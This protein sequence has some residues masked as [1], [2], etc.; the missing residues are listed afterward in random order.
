MALHQELTARR[1]ERSALPVID[2]SGLASDDLAARRAVARELRAACLDKGFFYIANHG[3][4]TPLVDTLLE[5]AARFFDLPE[6]EKLALDL[7]RSPCSHGYEPL[8]RQTLEAGAPADLKEGFYMGREARP[9]ESPRH[10]GPN[11]WPRDLPGFEAAMQAYYRAMG[12][13]AA[14]LMRGLALS[15]DLEEEY[16][17]G[18]C[19]AP[20]ARLRLLHY[21][22]Q[23]PGAGPGEK[24]AGAH[25]DFGGV[26]ILR[27]DDCGGLQVFDNASGGWIHADPMPDTFVVNLGDMVARWTND[28]Y[29]STLHRVVNVSGRERYSI[30]FFFHGNLGHVVECLPSCRDADASARY[31]TTTVEAHFREKFGSSYATA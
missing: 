21:P 28:R 20:F 29:R 1:V 11:Q 15:L 3:V 12:T 23:P 5:N 26:T 13:L 7:A 22:P 10:F 16:F 27:Q 6:D 4:P 25:T 8:K 2:V 17:A 9:G 14:R 30:P 19:Q 24:G 31:P 18:F